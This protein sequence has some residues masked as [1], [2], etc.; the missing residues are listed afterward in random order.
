MNHIKY[1]FHP[2]LKNYENQNMPVIPFVIPLLQKLMG[3][4]CRREKSDIDVTVSQLTIPSKDGYNLRALMYT[5]INANKTT[6]CFLFFHGGG[7]V[8]NAAPHHFALARNMAKALGWKTILLDYRLAPKYKYPTAPEDC[9]STYH[10]ILHNADSLNINP[11]QIAVCGDSAGGNLATVLCLM[12]RDRGI[13]IPM[14][15]MLLYPV[16]DRRM[17]TC[18]YQ[19]YTDTPMCNS[20]DMK[21]YFDMYVKNNSP[22][23]ITYLSPIES[24]SLIGLPPA[25]VETAE[26]DCLHDEGIS[27]AKAMQNAGIYVEI[28]ETQNTMHGYDIAIN[29]NLIKDLINQR[30]AFLQK[31]TNIE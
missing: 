6:P 8:Y 24:D 4:L 21:K 18:S 19:K 30:V 2:D 29:S 16:I 11:T 13:Q 14:A 22:A 27:Y 9:F 28:H 15:Q 23:N 26:Y 5:P 3:I 12:A 31:F 25:Y 7:F 1:N 10:W 17:E 20:K